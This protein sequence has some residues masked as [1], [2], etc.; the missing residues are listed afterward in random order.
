MYKNLA[1]LIILSVFYRSNAQ[2]LP[3]YTSQMQTDL[4]AKYPGTET[5]Q[6]VYD[7]YCENYT[8]AHYGEKS[9]VLI[10][11]P[12][13]F[14]VI[15]NYGPENI[16]DAQ[17]EDAIAI[18]NRDYN[19]QNPDTASVIPEFQS[20]IA[21]IQVEFKL[22]RID[23]YGNCT[24]G[25]DRIVSSKT[26]TGNDES[27]LN[28]WPRANYLNIW[29]VKTIGLSGAA[30]YAYYPGS[31]DG[32]NSSI[33]GIISLSDYVGSIGTSSLSHGR[34]LT[35]EVGHYLNL[36]HCWGNT[37][38]PGVSCG[39]DGV[40][41]TPKTRGWSFC[42]TPVV[43]TYCN[44]PIVENYQNYMDYSFCSKMFT[45]GQKQ[46]MYAALNSNV[47]ARNNLW[48]Q[49][50]L[51]QTGVLNPPV[52]CAPVPDLNANKRFV[53]PGENIN[54]SGYSINATATSWQWTFPGGAPSSSN[55]QNP[56]NIMYPTPGL[57][58]VTLTI[59]N[60]TDTNTITLDD[61]IQ[62]S[63]FNSDISGDL[64]ENFETG[65]SGLW[66]VLNPDNNL[67]QWQLVDFAGSS[68]NHCMQLNGEIQSEGDINEIISPSF[69]LN[70]MNNVVL[71]F[72]YA[73][74]TLN[75]DT[76]AITD[77]LNVY[78]SKDCGT[79]WSQ[80]LQLTGTELIKEGVV[81][82]SFVPDSG[83][84]TQKTVN[85]PASMTVNGLRVKFKYTSGLNSNNFYIDDV[86]F[87]GVLS[88]DEIV[89]AKPVVT[90]TPNPAS[91]NATVNLSI[92]S[93]GFVAIEL[94]DIA[95][96]KVTDIFSGHQASLAQSYPINC[97]NKIN[98]LAK[99]IYFVK[100]N[101]HGKTVGMS[102]L[103]FY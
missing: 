91:E 58:D 9:S 36:R 42:P 17:I 38:N 35:H 64:T 1:A 85:I 81:Q 34:T 14:H 48:T 95:G 59:A 8:A 73:G 33:D 76:A 30:A 103:V 65:T 61:Y 19:K 6:Q 5:F 16:S 98:K 62:V 13:V 55:I 68:G 41:D 83:S 99:G 18:L 2:M 32:V 92:P 82:G 22:A 79:V 102:K 96:A 90:I 86:N 70:F 56:T 31:V 57:Y 40:A 60:A 45:L 80:R 25:I 3:C 43:A 50:N 29:S 49:A 100:V 97:G 27:K 28:P 75:T 39:D 84:W 4:F 24:N 26:Y 23:P 12:V 66:Q 53:C 78:L 89:N 47:S 11:I 67:Q 63:S 54:F 20:L 69:D 93:P 71:S 21:D 10:T 52:V 37:N 74:S 51:V 87:T 15:H 46:R 94:Y 7:Q 44:P 101:I 77:K 72:K 88:T